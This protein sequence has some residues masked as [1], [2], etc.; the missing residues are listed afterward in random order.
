V[1]ALASL[2][3]LVGGE[4]RE[5]AR[6]AGPHLLQE[7]AVKQLRGLDQFV[8]R[9]AL[10]GRQ[11]RE[12]GADLHRRKTG[13]LGVE[14]GWGHLGLRRGLGRAGRDKSKRHKQD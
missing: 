1:Q 11:G 7:E 4:A 13:N 2:F 5:Q 9:L 3:R 10:V 12:V 8:Q 6:I 14:R